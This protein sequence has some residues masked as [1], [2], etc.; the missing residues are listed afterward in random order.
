MRAESG[1]TPAFL[2][3]HGRANQVGL[4]R[5]FESRGAGLDFEPRGVG[6]PRPRMST[7]SFTHSVFA[8]C[9]AGALCV[10]AACGSTQSSAR[11]E[12]TGRALRVRYLAYASGQKFE[13]VNDSHSE[14][15]QVYS[16]TKKLEDAFTKVTPDEVLDETIANFKASGY[17]EHAGPGSAPLS[18]SGDI[19]QALEVEESGRTSFWALSKSAS[20]SDVKSFVA[21]KQLFLYVYNNTYQL[22]SVENAPDWERQNIGLRKKKGQ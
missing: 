16:T 1:R 2:S 18:A 12:K 11:P 20:Q 10:L 14:R 15:T 8:T 21:C 22:Q 6:V 19:S 13:L 3:D 9:M 7:S 4:V 17:F 5:R